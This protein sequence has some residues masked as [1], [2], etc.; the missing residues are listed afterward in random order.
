[1]AR[2]YKRLLAGLRFVFITILAFL[3]L[4]P[5]VKYLFRSV[6]KPIVVIATDN[7][8]S[9]IFNKD[10]TFYRDT[11]P[12]LLEELRKELSDSYEVFTYHFAEKAGDS[13][14]TSFSGKET[15]MSSLLDDISIKYTNRNLGAVILASDGLFN[16][17][18]NPLY[19]SE[20]YPA[21]IYTVALGDTSIRKD[22]IISKVTHNKVVF[23]GNKFPLQIAVNAR[24]L[25]GENAVLTVTGNTGKLFEKTLSFNAID[26][27]D[28]TDVIL[29]ASTPGISRYRVAVSELKGEVTYVNNYA[30]IFIE[31]I[32][33]RQKILLLTEGP[34]P[35]VGTLYQVIAKN[36]N[37]QAEIQLTSAFKGNLA[38]YSLIIVNQLPSYSSN[39]S[40][41]I[42]PAQEKGIP[43]LFIL[44][45]ASNINSFNQ[46]NLGLKITG[47]RANTDEVQA[48]LNQDFT[49]FTL[50]DKAQSMI[51][52]Y[53]PLVSP[54]G[55][56]ETSTQANHLLFRKIGSV[57]TQTPLLSF[58]N[59]EKWKTAVISGEGIFK[60]RLYDY[61]IHKNHEAFDEL[62]SKIIQFLAVKEDKSYFRVNCP[63]EFPENEPVIIDAE[64]YNQSYELINAPEV[65]IEIINRE[66]KKFPFTFT[67]KNNAYYLNAGLLPPGEYAYTAT[68]NFEGKP[69]AK[70]GLFTVKPLQIE[71]VN[72][73]ADHG[74][75]YSMANRS[76]GEMVYP[77]DMLGLKDKIKANEKIKPLSQSQKQLKD[78]IHFK[79]I[80]FVLLAFISLEWFLRKREGVY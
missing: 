42:T 38:D 36:K 41:F 78:L 37:Y 30:D 53:P 40:T 59:Q 25:K 67:R 70:S 14:K 73:V 80:F 69:Y 31:V 60:W 39:L 61:Q 11:Y 8:E 76:G 46:I 65:R 72:T 16:K 27:L 7:S 48:L 64:L 74:L 79:W 51:S 2:W 19:I 55:N 10:S 18:S 12:G 58:F 34:H 21:P 77:A 57:A 4:S 71:A 47:N 5:L 28:L 63:G 54:F 13:L 20:H 15:D 22:L 17:G 6:E 26:Q 45:N 50:S 75:M 43:V 68:V 52:K 56:Y 1:M 44:G 23:L 32:D 49:L 24:K 33:S 35:D 29:E 66:K 62:F 9:V 3:L